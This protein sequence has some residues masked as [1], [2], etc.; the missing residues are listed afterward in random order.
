MRAS[1]FLLVGLEQSVTVRGDPT[2][3]NRG[4]KVTI[5]ATNQGDMLRDL[6][7]RG[8]RSQHKHDSARCR[9]ICHI[10]RVETETTYVPLRHDRPHRRRLNAQC[11]ITDEWIRESERAPAQMA[12]GLGGVP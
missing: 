9:R 7:D 12:Q 2:R 3:L 8:T 6:C 10:P 11:Y 1:S 4:Q 5:E